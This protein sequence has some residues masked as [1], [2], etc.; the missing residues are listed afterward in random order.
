MKSQKIISVLIFLTLV[1]SFVPETDA[2]FFGGYYCSLYSAGQCTSPGQVFTII[3]KHEGTKY[4]FS[5]F[6]ALVLSSVPE[7]EG[8]FLGNY[9][10]NVYAPSQCTTPGRVFTMYSPSQC[11]TPGNVF[12]VT[13][14]NWF[15]TKVITC[16][17]PGTTAA[18]PAQG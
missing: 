13:V 11:T 16:Q 8:F 3:S 9:W 10:C 7:T 15:W 18:P 5:F 1:S 4:Y 12:T 2:F 6:C 14:G 17:C